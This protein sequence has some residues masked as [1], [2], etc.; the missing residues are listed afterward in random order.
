MQPLAGT[1]LATAA[2]GANCSQAV[3]VADAGRTQIALAPGNYVFVGRSPSFDKGRRNCTAN[4]PVVVRAEKPDASNFPSV[5]VD[6][7]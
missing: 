2:S 6:C 7:K 3:N 1:V 5:T 4:G